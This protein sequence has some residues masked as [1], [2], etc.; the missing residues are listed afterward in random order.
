MAQQDY[1]THFE[2]SQTFDGAKTDAAEKNHLN[3]RKQNLA[4][5]MLGS[6]PQ[7][8]DDKQFTALKISALNHS[9]T[10]APFR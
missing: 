4:G 2:P 6:N 5:L 9:A 3:T 1:F 7:R 10:R 8:W